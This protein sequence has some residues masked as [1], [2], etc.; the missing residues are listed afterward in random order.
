MNVKK[1]H[2]MLCPFQLLPFLT[3][4]SGG[5]RFAECS[6]GVLRKRDDA[7]NDRKKEEPWSGHV[8]SFT[9]SLGSIS[10]IT[11]FWIQK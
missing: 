3:F 8:D 6:Q 1:L 4:S 7:K 10:R 2:F 5:L 9:F 11:D